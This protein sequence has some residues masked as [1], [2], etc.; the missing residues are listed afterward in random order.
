MKNISAGKNFL[1]FYKFL[2]VIFSVFLI[3]SFLPAQSIIKPECK[4]VTLFGLLQPVCPTGYK[5]QCT[6]NKPGKVIC[7]SS[8][9]INDPTV[10]HAGVAYYPG[11]TECVVG[12]TCVICTQAIPDCAPGFRPVGQT[13]DQCAHCE[14]CPAV[15]CTEPPVGC[16]YINAPTDGDGCQVGCGEL[17]C[18]CPQLV[19]AQ[20]PPGCRY[21]DIPVDARGCQAGCGRLDCSCPGDHYL[22]NGVCTPRENCGLIPLPLIPHLGFSQE[23]FLPNNRIDEIKGRTRATDERLANLFDARQ[24]LLDNKNPRCLSISG[25]GVNVDAFNFTLN[26]VIKDIDRYESFRVHLFSAEAFWSSVRNHD[27]CLDNEISFRNIR[28]IVLNL[29]SL[30]GSAILEIPFDLDPN[31]AILEP[32]PGVDNSDVNA[33]RQLLNAKRQEYKA[34]VD[35]PPCTFVPKCPNDQYLNNGVCAPRESCGLLPLPLIP[36]LGF[37]RQDFHPSVR[38][39]EIETKSGNAFERLQY[40]I[41]ADIAFTNNRNPKCLSISGLL[42]GDAFNFTHADIKEDLIRF[43]AYKDYLFSAKFFWDSVR[44]HD[45]CLDNEISF[46]N[47]RTIVL[48]LES[49]LGSAILEIPFDLDPNTA[50]LEPYPG[51]DNSDVNAIRQLLNAKRQEYKALVDDPPCTFVPKC[52]NDQ[53]LNN[54]VCAPRESCGLLPLPLIPHLGFGRQDFHPSVRLEEIETKSGNAFERLQY[55]ID[56]DIAFTNNRNPKCLSISGLLSGDAFN[57]THADIKEDLIR[58]M[59]YKDYLFSAKFFWDSVRNHDICL[60]NEISFRNIRTIVLNLES[61]LGSAI[62]EIPFDLDPNTAIL[63]P[64]PGVDNS[65]VNAIR[66]LLNAKRQ[67]YKA[68]VDDPSCINNCTNKCGTQC[69]NS[70]ETCITIDPCRNGLCSAPAIQYCA[71]LDSSPFCIGGEIKCNS[72][73]PACT[74]PLQGANIPTCGEILGFT[75]EAKGPAC[76]NQSK[77]VLNVGFVSCSDTVVRTSSNIKKRTCSKKRICPKGKRFKSCRADKE[78]CKCICP[79]ERSKYTPRCNKSDKVKCSGKL[80]PACSEESNVP[81]CINSKLACQ[82]LETGSLDLADKI[83]CKE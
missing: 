47:I 39:E 29:E 46:R 8:Y 18:S 16:R 79:F 31:T 65:D 55:L 1:Q 13:C 26:D 74:N 11:A 72:G 14:Q 63:E 28:T 61:L 34:L 56:A 27:I 7:D 17:E 41:D 64:Y 36:H 33:I 58:F 51:V 20:P 19:C 4:Q 77:T 42:S 71:E 22:N 32:Y 68:L 25:L 3:Q 15:L 59:A 81:V 35:D 53:Y 54:G 75:G 50:I 70:S 69:C 23:E 12:N 60:D 21:V 10:C 52:P 67:E 83:Y 44:N 6:G 45:I 37:G 62:L 43:M 38:L 66:Q 78:S 9:D 5:P 57:F 2:V 73:S 49:L 40:L 48:N 80:T 76:V 30:L 82:D 24:A